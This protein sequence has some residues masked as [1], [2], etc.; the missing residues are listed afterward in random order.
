VNTPKNKK[1]APAA[2]RGSKRRK[3]TK[4]KLIRLD[5]LIPDQDVKGGRQLLFGLT[6]TDTNDK[7]PK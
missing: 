4:D 6:D 7:Q 3:R 2:E 1:D 5:D